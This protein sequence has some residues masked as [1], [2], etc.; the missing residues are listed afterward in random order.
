MKLSRLVWLIT[1]CCALLVGWYIWGYFFDT[2]VPQIDVVG[3]VEGNYYSGDVPCLLKAN[4]N[5]ILSIVLDGKLLPSGYITKGKSREYS[6]ILPTTSLANGNHTVELTFTDNTFHHTSKKV[7]CNFI[8]DN[9]PLHASLVG[10]DSSKI[11]QGH[12]LHIQ[13]QTNKPIKIAKVQALCHEYP[14]VP[15]SVGSSLYECFIPIACEEQPNAY[16]ASIEINDHVNNTLHLDYT[17]H[18]VEYPFKRQTIRID[19]EKVKSEQDAWPSEKEFEALLAH[20]VCKSPSEKKWRGAFCAPTEIQ[21]IS[22]EFG[23]LRTTQHKGRYAH[24][25]LDI[26]NL[27]HSV[28]WAP[29]DGVVV[30]KDR[31]A[32]SGN[33]V[34]LDHGCGVFSLLFHLEDFADIHVGDM[35]AQGNPLGI[36]GKTGYATGVHLHWEHRVDNIPVD[37]MEWTKAS[38]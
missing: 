22:C 13:F 15:E 4:K 9:I 5:G 23:T 10:V 33:T 21:R 36:I 34:V 6:F 24:K 12:T 37:P 28:V 38:F 29:Q 2:S 3:L 14:C 8:S 7:A 26:I 1:S 11:S 30:V 19:Q 27:P 16:I 31:F 17:F 35:V 32:A 25:A 20:L 18:V